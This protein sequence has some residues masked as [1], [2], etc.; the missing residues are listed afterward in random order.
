[1]F[2]RIGDEDGTIYLECGEFDLALEFSIDPN[3]AVSQGNLLIF[4]RESSENDTDLF[5][6]KNNRDLTAKNLAFA[7]SS[8]DFFTITL[9]EGESTYVCR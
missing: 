8:L 5:I 9:K 2:G 3:G 7:L 1:M 6:P 4:H